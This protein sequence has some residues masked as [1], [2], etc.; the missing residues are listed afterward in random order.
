[1]ARAPFIGGIVVGGSNTIDG[2]LVA[3]GALTAAGAVQG[4]S[5]VATDGTHTLT[6]TPGATNAFNS[7]LA[8]NYQINGVNYMQVNAAGNI[9][10]VAPASG[11]ALTVTGSPT[12]SAT[13]NFIGGSGN[14]VFFQLTSSSG[15]A[16]AFRVSGLAG[17]AW[18]LYDYTRAA[19]TLRWTP[20]AR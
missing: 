9:N 4:A 8:I 5:V 11:V 14:N 7:S 19:S 18:D 16:F 3:T 20:A 13:A 1:M 17:D 10:N 12:A 2:S 6:W 15:Q